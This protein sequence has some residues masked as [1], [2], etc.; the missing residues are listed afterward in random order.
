[1]HTAIVIGT[2]V[3]LSVFAGVMSLSGQDNPTDEAFEGVAEDQIEIALD[4]PPE[5]LL[6]KIDFMP[7]SPENE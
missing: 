6:G 1:M 5:A 2:F 4:L 3:I 7:G